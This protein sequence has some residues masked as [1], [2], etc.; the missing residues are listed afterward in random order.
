M[1]NFIAVTENYNSALKFG[2][3]KDF[4]IKL[5]DW[6]G[7]R[8]SLWTGVSIG[9]IIAVGYSNFSKFLD[10]A[11]IGDKHFVQKDYDKNIPVI[12]ALLSFYYT[13]FFYAQTHLVLPY[14]YRLRFLKEHL[15][16][17]EMESNGKSLDKNGKSL[18]NI[19]GNIIWGATG[20][21]SQHSFYQLLHQ[22]KTF[23]PSDFI[24]SSKTDSGSQ[25]NHDKLFSNYLS[26]IEILNNGFTK[27]EALKLYDHKFSTLDLDKKLVVKNL[28]LKG[29]KPTNAILLKDMSPETLGI[30]LSFYEHKTYILGLL[31]NVNSFDQW[32]VEIGKIKANDIYKSIKN[33][34]MKNKKQKDVLI[35][36]YLS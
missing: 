25:D 5:W 4:I 19:S 26:H 33:S 22:G 30:L 20:N 17:L 23:I 27:E 6:I 36:K 32:A 31:S 14:N 1:K 9:L 13:R 21:C 11:R 12:M 2:I 29:N 34:K 16:Q 3:K 24:I 15:Q 7:G 8:Y 28:M 10:G 35:K 18:K